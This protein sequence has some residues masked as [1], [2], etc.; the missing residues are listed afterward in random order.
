[1]WTVERAIETTGLSRSTV[2]RYFKSLCNVG[3]LDP[4][5]GGGYVLGPGIIE[6]DR[7]IRL[8]DRLLKFARPAMQTLVRECQSPVYLYRTYA[9]KVVCVYQEVP[10][11]GNSGDAN[12]GAVAPMFKDAMSKVVL[13]YLP[14]RR[15]RILQNRFNREIADPA[16]GKDWNQFNSQLRAIRRAGHY[17]SSNE[18]DFVGTAIAAGVLDSDRRILGGLCI[19]MAN[20]RSSDERAMTAIKRLREATYG[21]NQA[22]EHSVD[23]NGQTEIY[24]PR[25]TAS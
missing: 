23:D 19:R 4:V 6:L 15:L 12:R 1:M 11:G 24:R 21:I 2:Y 10:G 20:I 8:T 9:D 16:T 22:V 13:A 17:I 18:E 25:P 5:S 3:L 7:R 14:A